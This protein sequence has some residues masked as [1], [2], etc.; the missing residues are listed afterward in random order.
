MFHTQIIQYGAKVLIPLLHLRARLEYRAGLRK[1]SVSHAAPALNKI[2]GI[3]SDARMLWRIWG[4]S[5]ILLPPHRLAVELC[6]TVE[7][8]ILQVYFPSY[9]GWS[10]LSALLRLLGAY[11]PLNALKA[12]ACS[13]TTPWSTST[14]FFHTELSPLPSLSLHCFP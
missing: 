11:S 8:K 6:L 13:S 14:T 2:A 9:N 3:I 1:D 12:G 4:Q 5:L 7:N 10:P